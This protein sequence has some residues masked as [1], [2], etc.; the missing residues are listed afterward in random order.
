M[1]KRVKKESGGK[2]GEVHRPPV[3]Q[4]V[5]KHHCHKRGP[6]EKKKKNQGGDGFMQRN[7]KGKQSRQQTGREH[8]GKK[9]K[10]KIPDAESDRG[11]R[12]GQERT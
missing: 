5:R 7:R 2:G 3:S 10:N 9:K 1:E 12:K 11:W 8:M 4:P 6:S